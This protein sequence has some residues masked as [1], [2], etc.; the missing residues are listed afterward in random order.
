MTPTAPILLSLKPRW[1]HLASLG[2]HPISKLTIISPFLAQ[3]L[4]SDQKLIHE[5]LVRQLDWSQIE[6]LYWSLIC[7]SIGQL[8]F[9][10]N[11]PKEIKQFGTLQNYISSQVQALSDSSIDALFFEKIKLFFIPYGGS[12]SVDSVD[13]NYDGDVHCVVR[14]AAANQGQRIDSDGSI[15]TPRT[16][17]YEG[18]WTEFANFITSLQNNI[19]NGFN[20]G[21][22]GT[23]LSILID[24]IVS[25]ENRGEDSTAF[26]SLIECILKY[27]LAPQWK[28]LVLEDR[29]EYL[30]L[31]KR[32]TR[33]LCGAFYAIGLSYFLWHTPVLVWN[34]FLQSDLRAILGEFLDWLCFLAGSI[35]ASI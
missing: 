35:F 11:C 25:K 15:I 8:I 7:L 30:N 14:D 31:T 20:C 2:N 3:V 5:F 24:L 16:P 18:H 6:W 32:F 29:F 33:Y 17:L 26:G 27:R 1:S 12:L 10:F 19:Y 21:V 9:L 34:V 28:I 4:L 13:T 23:H 22:V